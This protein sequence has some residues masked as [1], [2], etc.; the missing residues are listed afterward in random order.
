MW[1]G[2]TRSRNSRSAEP[3]YILNLRSYDKAGELLSLLK[4]LLPPLKGKKVLI[5]PNILAPRKPEEG[6]T[7]HPSICKTVI[8]AVLAKGGNPVIGDCPGVSGYGACERAGEV[9]GI[10]AVSQ[11]FFVNF[12]RE[13]KKIQTPSRLIP[14]IAVSKVLFEV[15]YVIN[16]PKFKTHALTYLTGAIKNMFGVV[17]GGDKAM[18]H[19]M[20][21]SREDFAEA[22]LDIFLIRKPDLTVMDGIVA[23]E[24]NGPTGG[25]L[26]NAGMVLVSRDAFA[27]DVL[28]AGIAGINPL[29]V[30][31]IK[32]GKERGLGS[33]ELDA[34]R[35][36]GKFNSIKGFRMPSTYYFSF[37]SPFTYLINRYVFP[38]FTKEKLFFIKRRCNRCKTCI[39]EC[40]SG[41]MK[42]GDDGYPFIDKKICINC[43]CCMELCPEQAW[44]LGGFINRLRRWF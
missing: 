24:G 44:T 31:V 7:T 29:T 22:L 26:I 41:A 6:I 39:N 23:M 11:D 8:E 4:D 27:V 5:K 40:P 14:E 17:V 42:L 16:V 21:P 15:D 13:A 12:A 2:S 33:G 28:M 10:K 37:T 43:Y 9:S 20:A 38:S 1:T 30:P 19:R 3:V 25:N 18:V 34:L 32:K 35:V 36:E